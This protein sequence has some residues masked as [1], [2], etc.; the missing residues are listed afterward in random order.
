VPELS[1]HQGRTIDERPRADG[2]RTVAAILSALIVSAVV[3]G[4]VV[5]FDVR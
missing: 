1:Q 5:F 3:W 2:R 4:V